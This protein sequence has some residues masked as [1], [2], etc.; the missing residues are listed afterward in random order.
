MLRHSTSG[1][2]DKAA[3]TLIRRVQNEARQ[4]GG[5]EASRDATPYTP[6]QILLP[7]A[8]RVIESLLIP[9]GSTILR[10]LVGLLGARGGICPLYQITG[11]LCRR[12]LGML[13]Q[14]GLLRV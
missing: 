13:F 2:F 3:S 11:S 8:F 1:L 5:S 12:Y 4:H 14:W 6:V 9:A 10:F 7:T